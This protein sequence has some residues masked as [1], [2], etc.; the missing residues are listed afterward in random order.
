MNYQNTISPIEYLQRK[1]IEY[2]ESVGELIVKCVFNDCD[3]DSQG[4]E[5]HLNINKETGV[6]RC[7]KCNSSG[8]LITLA[9]HLGDDL[10]DLYPY[11]AATGS[12]KPKKASII[13]VEL[14][15]KCH[16]ALPD[17]LRAYLNGRGIVN[18]I[19]DSFKLGYGLFYGRN[20]I[21]FPVYDAGGKLLF[22]KL[23]K[24]PEDVSNSDKGKFYPPKSEAALYNVSILTD[25]EEVL[26]CEGECDCLIAISKGIPAVTSTAGAGTFKDEW[27]DSFRKL[28][29]VLVCYDRDDAGTRGAATVIEKLTAL[30]G[31]RVRQIVLPEM[32]E[33]K[34]LTDYFTSFGGNVDGLMTLAREIPISVASRRIKAVAIP[35]NEIGIDEWRR[36]IA[37]NFPDCAFAAEVCLS[38]VA[39]MLILDI[40]NPFAL[41]LVD[42][43]SSG[44]TIT[45]NMFSEIPDITYA[46]DKFTPASFVS[47]ASNVKKE[48]L[49]EI[50]LLPRLRYKTFLI[51]D[52]ATLFGERED[53]LQKSLGTLTRVLDGE[54]FQTDSGTHGQRQYV[55]EYLF[56]MIA[57]ST[58]I[59]P[60]VW[61]LMGSLGPRLFFLHL[62]SKDRTEEELVSQLRNDSHKIKE[63]RCREATKNYLYGL[64]NQNH[65]GVEWDKKSD[66]EEFLLIISRCAML[67]AKLRGTIYVG[68]ERQDDGAEYGHTASIIEKPHRINQ[69]LYNLCRGHALIAG[70]RQVSKYDLRI[71]I[72]IVMDS[73]PQ[74]RAKLFRCLIEHDGKMTTTQVEYDLTCS[75][76]T[77]LKEMEALKILGVVY[78][79]GESTGKV[80]EPEKIIRLKSNLK[81]FLSEECGEIRGLPGQMSFDDVDEAGD[82]VKTLMELEAK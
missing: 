74:S 5:A 37:E 72:E 31:P 11:N 36:I 55:G 10:K 71:I 17:R 33:G 30:E 28:K 14:A 54:G 15:E 20:W 21:T 25:T 58:P 45:L 68:K 38:I 78:A 9:K 49:A 44:K 81:W 22:L 40:T 29:S 50:D 1:G 7:V 26:V 69:L 51:R 53:D 76:P 8:N 39:Q 52:L 27:L 3:M 47:N 32:G 62:S 13:S 48:K 23:R 24:D 60:R 73:A 65:D 77:A 80:G 67:L 42:V 18:Q 75:K 41:V 34:D 63:T 16:Q 61:K 66:P 64:W 19:I 35:R 57:A 12:N 4:R 59:H 56:M 2:R 79:T 6:Y 82:D 70:R 46:T 43:P